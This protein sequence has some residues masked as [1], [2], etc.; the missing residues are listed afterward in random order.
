MKTLSTIA[1]ALFL[2]LSFSSFASDIPTTTK[3]SIDNRVNK[4]I[5]A[6]SLGDS[7]GV[8]EILDQSLTYRFVRGTEIKTYGKA[9]LV[10]AMK[11]AGKAEQNCSTAYHMLE[12][13]EGQTVVVLNQKYESFTKFT[14]LTF[15]DT[16]EG[17]KI[18]KIASWFE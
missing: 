3:S 12:N 18:S 17:L 6:I 10:K 1:A 7:E 9:D 11:A 5:R 4:Y 14:R 13:E 16:K 15:T 2:V 8:E